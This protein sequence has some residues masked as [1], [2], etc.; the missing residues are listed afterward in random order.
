VK[1]ESLG[2]VLSGAQHMTVDPQEGL[3]EYPGD[4]LVSVYESLIVIERLA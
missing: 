1:H 3:R 4:P 2:L